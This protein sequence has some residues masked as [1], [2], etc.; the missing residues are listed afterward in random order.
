MK[1]AIIGAAYRQ[2]PPPPGYQAWTVG[3]CFTPA[4]H[5]AYELHTEQTARKW[6]PAIPPEALWTLKP[7]AHF[8][9]NTL[10]T[11]AIFAISPKGL[12]STISWMV[13]HAI[14]QQP[15]EIK[16]LGCPMLAPSH[17]RFAPGTSFW[18]GIALGRNIKITGN[19]DY[20]G[21]DLYGTHF[22]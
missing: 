21:K 16:I 4:Y 8:P 13:A 17:R 10:P 3:H 5:R 7:L 1:I 2:K 15:S 22:S 18:T 14:L 20:V 12:T 9:S 11:A 6:L 19:Y